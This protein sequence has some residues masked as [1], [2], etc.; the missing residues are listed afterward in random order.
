MIG[1]ATVM[2]ICLA[3]MLL[4]ALS[5]SGQLRINTL[6][7]HVCGGFITTPHFQVGVS[8]VSPV[9]S[10]LPP[11]MLSPYKICVDIPA[12]LQVPGA[13]HGEWLLPP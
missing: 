4:G 11:L 9:S 3:C 5:W 2:G 10:Y 1:A 8:W 12:L 13:L 7:L 6:S